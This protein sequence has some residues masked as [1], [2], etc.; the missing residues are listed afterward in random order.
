[1]SPNDS[2]CTQPGL[3]TTQPILGIDGH[4]DS[5]FARVVMILSVWRKRA[6]QRRALGHLDAHL[7]MDIGVD[8]VTAKQEADKPFWRV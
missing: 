5:M 7:L 4:T 3:L 1:M 2:I 6:K 8:R